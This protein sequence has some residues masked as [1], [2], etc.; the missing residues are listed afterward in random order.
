M[1]KDKDV[2]VKPGIYFMVQN[3]G[4][5]DHGCDSFQLFLISFGVPDDFINEFLQ[6]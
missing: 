4:I 5:I 6:S 3:S 1:M 2:L